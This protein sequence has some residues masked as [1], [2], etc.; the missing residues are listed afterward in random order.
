MERFRGG[1]RGGWPAVDV[2]PIPAGRPALGA[3][4]RLPGPVLT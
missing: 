2:P 3:V 1:G 4:V